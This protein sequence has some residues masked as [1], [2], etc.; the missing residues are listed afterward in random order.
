MSKL[1]ASD[2]ATRPRPVCARPGQPRGGG[3]A[4]GAAGPGRVSGVN[5]KRADLR[6]V[7]LSTVPYCSAFAVA[8]ARHGTMVSGCWCLFDHQVEA[9]ELTEEFRRR[10]VRAGAFRTGR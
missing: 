2:C 5:A 1:A 7:D 8:E 10:G 6:G 4:C 3:E 9:T